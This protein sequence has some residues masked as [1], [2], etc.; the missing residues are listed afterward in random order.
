MAALIIIPCYIVS[1][2]TEVEL[3]DIFIIAAM[4]FEFK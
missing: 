2:I 1:S 3:M 4:H